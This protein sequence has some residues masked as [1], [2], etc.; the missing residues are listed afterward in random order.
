METLKVDIDKPDEKAIKKAARILKKG[1]L[2]VYPTDAAYGLGANAFD[3]TAV[4]KVYEVKGRDFS[5]PTHVIVRDWKMIEELTLT[6]D[7]AKRL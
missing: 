1:G 2:A 5:K 7:Y 3:E 6:N 4:R